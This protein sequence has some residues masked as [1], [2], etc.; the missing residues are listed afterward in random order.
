MQLVPKIFP[1][2]QEQR[3]IAFEQS[4]IRA[5]AKIGGQL[6]GP[7]PNGHNRQFF[8]LNESVWI[9]HEEW[10]ENGSRK[11][12][13]THYDVRSD[14]VIKTQDGRPVQ[15]VGKDEARNLYYAVELYQQRVDAI[16][17]NMLSAV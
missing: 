13:T 14:G 7:V 11:V 10:T 12:I 15:Y 6:F 2:S 3:R 4:L 5:E 8:C 16:Y 9:W 1:R 17:E